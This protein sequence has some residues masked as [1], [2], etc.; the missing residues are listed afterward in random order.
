MNG[1]S[2]TT[3]AIAIAVSLGTIAAVN[4]TQLRNF[5]KQKA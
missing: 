1:W 5:V 4:Q 3:W 2:L